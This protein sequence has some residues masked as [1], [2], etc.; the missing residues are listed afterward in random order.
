MPANRPTDPIGHISPH[1]GVAFRV[2]IG[3]CRFL[4]RGV[5]G[6]RLEL[7]GA[8]Y[9][10]RDPGGR[11]AGGWIA[12]P[13]PH[14]RWIDPFL[15]L[16]LLPLQPRLVFFADGRVL[17]KT[18]LRRVLFRLLGG[19]V[20]VWPHGGPRAFW[21]HIEA[22][23]RVL[24]AGAVF[25]IFPEA[26][27][28]S[29]P[30]RARR[31]EPGFGY[32]AMRTQARLVPMVIGGTGELYRRRRLVLQVMPANTA[33]ELAGLPA[34]ASLPEQNSAEERAVAHQIADR[35]AE[36]IA[37]A[38]AVLHADVE[39]TSAGDARRWPWLTDWLDWDADAADAARA[40]RK[41]GTG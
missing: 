22:A 18:R 38:I 24:D 41:A 29:S 14:R 31:V 10:P 9:L 16:L 6:L 27:P 25:V 15:L 13:L 19:V 20:P 28:P 8:E 37:P 12:V 23:R 30:D 40:A 7:H 1:P 26:G 35:F 17:F 39:R 21:A 36:R 4:A 34:T 33:Q 5:F 11:P 2:A 3:L 32:L